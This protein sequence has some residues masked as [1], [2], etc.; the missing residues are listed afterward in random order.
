[1]IELTKR[2]ALEACILMWDYLAANP[3]ATKG[4]A[5]YA[6]AL[7]YFIADCAACHYDDQHEGNC[8]NCPVWV[9]AYEDN[10]GQIFDNCIRK[11]NGE[12]GLFLQWDNAPYH[13]RSKS[14]QAIVDLACEQLAELETKAN[15]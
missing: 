13:Q 11:S 8:S 3:A 12:P 15:D 9:D 4:D 14:A 2:E 10:I 1:M 6:L 7:P 5:L